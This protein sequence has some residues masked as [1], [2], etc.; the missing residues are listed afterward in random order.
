MP[1]PP[2]P[3]TARTKPRPLRRR[4]ARAAASL[5]LAATTAFGV[6]CVHIPRANPAF[7]ASAV[8]VRAAMAEMRDNPVELER[9]ILVLSGWRS[10]AGAS[11]ALAADIR[12]LTGADSDQV[13]HMSYMWA[14]DLEPLGDRV[15]AF[16]D[17]RWPT[18]DPERT[19]EVDVVA[20]SMGGIVARWSAS[21]RGEGA[22]RLN[23]GMLYTL[24]TPHR[25]ALLADSIR[26]DRASAQM[27][28][29]SDM[30]AH[31]DADLEAG[32]YDVVPYAVLHDWLVGA[33]RSAPPGAEPIWVPGRVGMSH[34][35]VSREDRI[36]ADVAR[37]IRGEE[38]LGA[39]SEPPRN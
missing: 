15:V 16:V 36:I 33:T 21:D 20:I 32:A 19:T 6:S 12:R 25:G 27:R 28:A 34:H 22:R 35:M 39:P 14:G 29:G 7:P 2:T 13:T 1:K 11:R 8:E 38:P 3:S 24:A 30:L 10:P 9:P 18:D 4:L 5:G 17:E 23:I 37:R 31:L 26:I